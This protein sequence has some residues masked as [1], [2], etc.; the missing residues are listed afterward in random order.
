LGY[1]GVSS[2]AAGFDV[3]GVREHVGSVIGS[4]IRVV[5]RKSG[6]DVAGER[7]LLVS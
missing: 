6:S 1:L 3:D 7:V 2:K 5:L 4:E